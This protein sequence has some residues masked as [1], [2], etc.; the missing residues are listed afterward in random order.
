MEYI[1]YRLGL[2]FNLQIIKFWFL[3]IPIIMIR[4]FG[5]NIFSIDLIFNTLS[6]NMVWFFFFRTP[7]QFSFVIENT[8]MTNIHDNAIYLA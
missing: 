7:S 1:Y 5:N 8:R 4:D 6:N 2:D 3:K